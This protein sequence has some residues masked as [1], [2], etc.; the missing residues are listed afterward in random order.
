MDKRWYKK[1]GWLRDTTEREDHRI[2]HTAM[3]RRT[4]TAAEIRAAVDTTVAQRTVR[5]WLF[6]GQ[7]QARRP[8]ELITLTPS[9]CYCNATCSSEC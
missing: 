2:R 1:I 7:L 4:A 5:N 8:V 6:Q 3:A 9:H